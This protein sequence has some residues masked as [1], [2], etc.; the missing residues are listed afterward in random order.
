MR[1]EDDLARNELSRIPIRER[2]A[3]RLKELASQEQQWPPQVFA[4]D[5]S[6]SGV[7]LTASEPLST[8]ARMRAR[9]TSCSTP[10]LGRP[11]GVCPWATG[12]RPGT[13]RKV[14]Y[15]ARGKNADAAT[16]HVIDVASGKV[17]DVDVIEG[18]ECAG[19]GVDPEVRRLLLPVG[20][21]RSRPS[22][23][24]FFARRRPIP[25]ARR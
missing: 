4:V 18:A 3:K 14:V 17:S 16:L 1:Q 19:G 21:A 7:A 12:G 8:G 25:E 24:P 10:R 6:I 23:R 22:P 13:A 9:T 11:T 15:Q 5:S 20:L 2:L